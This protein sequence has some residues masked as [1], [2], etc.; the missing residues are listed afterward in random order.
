MKREIINNLN[1]DVIKKH[2]DIDVEN[3]FSL[4]DKVIRVPEIFPNASSTKI[5]DEMTSCYCCIVIASVFS[6]SFED[7]LLEFSRS[8]SSKNSNL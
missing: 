1:D 8:L 7:E 2:F 6:G 3:S 4:Y 5:S